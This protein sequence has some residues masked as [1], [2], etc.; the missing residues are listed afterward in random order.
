MT[1]TLLTA[2][3]STQTR[4]SLSASRRASLYQTVSSCLSNFLQLPPQKQDPAAAR[5]FVS[6]YTKDAAAQTLQALIWESEQP[7]SPKEQK[8]IR[9]KSL[10]LAEQ[11][12]STVDIQ[13][14]LNLAIV[15]ARTNSQR[16]RTIFST[17]IHENPEFLSSIESELVPAFARVLSSS[18]V[19]GLYG[20]RKAAHC[21]K[22]FLHVSPPEVV[23]S[24]AHSKEFIVE[25]AKAYNVGLGGIARS[26]GG[27]TGDENEEDDWKKIWVATKVDLLDSFHICLSTLLT[28][29]AS[30]SGQ[31]L[32]VEADRTFDILFALL[33]VPTASTSTSPLST[34][35]PFLNQS[36]LADY[37]HSYDLERTLASSLKHAAEKDARLDILES[38]LRSFNSEGGPKG[39]PGVLKLLIRSSGLPPGVSSKGKGKAAAPTPAPAPVEADPDIDIKVASVLDILPDQSPEYIKAL[40][41]HPDFPY[42]GDTEKVVDALLGGTAPSFEELTHSNHKL[43][44]PAAKPAEDDIHAYVKSRQGV[45][46]AMDP[47]LISFGKKNQNESSTDFLADRSEIEQ[48]KADILRRA[49]AFSDSEEEEVAPEQEDPDLDMQNPNIKISGDGEE[50]NENQPELEEEAEKEK[51]SIE[52]ILERAYVKDAAL[53]NRDAVTRRSKT[54]EELKSKTGWSDEQI[55]GWKIMLERDPKKKERL[56]RK[57]E[58]EAPQNHLVPP[59][60]SSSSRGRGRGRGGGS[61]GGR[62]G[63]GNNE[64]RDRAR[65]ERQGNQVRRRGHDKKVA[66]TGGIPSEW[67]HPRSLFLLC[68]P[69]PVYGVIDRY[70]IALTSANWLSKI[71]GDEPSFFNGVDP[72]NNHVPLPSNHL[73]DL[74]CCKVTGVG[75]Y[76]SRGGPKHEIIVLHFDFGFEQRSVRLQRV[77]HKDH[78]PMLTGYAFVDDVVIG[79]FYEPGHSEFTIVQKFAVPPSMSFNILQCATLA[80]AITYVSWAYSAR[81]YM[82]LWWA[83]TF[84]NCARHM[85]GVPQLVKGPA[86]QRR[87]HIGSTLVVNDQC[88]LRFPSGS[89]M[90]ALLAR[91]NRGAKAHERRA[92][93]EALEAAYNADQVRLER[94]DQEGLRNNPKET[95]LAEQEVLMRALV[96]ELERRCKPDKEMSSSVSFATLTDGIGCL[97]RLDRRSYPLHD[98]V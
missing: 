8:E 35:T 34:R 91:M 79:P 20:I 90:D 16:T 30:A 65:K 86:F 4:Q 59:P 10:L 22:S 68:A 72:D 55:E 92:T 41:S 73:D 19:T 1:V 56:I 93:L 75:H 84:F 95:V 62:G 47:S 7:D 45:N 37:Q 5:T 27:F 60:P 44:T 97:D 51:E 85:C 3:P 48:L 29:L 32:V 57:Y 12:A 21:I 80:H 43:G 46:E 50:E 67:Y 39:S 94:L 49:E 61:R 28:D 64:A 15:Y 70:L 14:L 98:D 82:C 24:F 2:W 23:R 26:Y 96:A 53:F 11:I 36:L 78:C 74:L 63:G 54:R 88:Q 25:L 9:K 87:G 13:A 69:K 31:R 81:Q 38:S 6:T 71:L 66:K 52:V 40:L 17:V 33:E 77:M 83:G 42:R 58:N 18:N 76:R 89:E